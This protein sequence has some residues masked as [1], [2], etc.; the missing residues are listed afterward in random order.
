V[1]HDISTANHVTVVWTKCVRGTAMKFPEFL[2]FY[3]VKIFMLHM[4]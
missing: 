1:S 3:F 4:C 2:S